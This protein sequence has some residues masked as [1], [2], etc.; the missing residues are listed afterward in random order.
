MIDARDGEGSAI[1]ILSRGVSLNPRFVRRDCGNKLG[2]GRAGRAET[3]A[4]ATARQSAL[5]EMYSC[6]EII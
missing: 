1:Q 5:T 6:H 3:A 2:D 4:A